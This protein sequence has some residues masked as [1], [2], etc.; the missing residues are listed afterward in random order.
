MPSREEQLKQ[1]L[2]DLLKRRNKLYSKGAND[3]SLNSKIRE[4]Q[5]E[6]RKLNITPEY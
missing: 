1:Q 6:L 2:E 4:V 3:E 5:S